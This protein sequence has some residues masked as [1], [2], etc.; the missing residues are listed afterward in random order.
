MASKLILFSQIIS[1]TDRGMFKKLAGVKELLRPYRLIVKEQLFI[2]IS[3]IN[4]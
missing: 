4:I 3:I 2:V 1:K